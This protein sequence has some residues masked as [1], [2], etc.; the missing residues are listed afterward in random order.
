M[1]QETEA[2]WAGDFGRAYTER[3]A[4]TVDQAFQFF[5]HV[6]CNSRMKTSK[7]DRVLELGANR[8]HNL[9]AIKRQMSWVRT[10]AV[11]INGYAIEA[12]IEHGK[13]GRAHV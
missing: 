1:K 12:M 4:V 8:G 10:T 9:A 11:E 7:I 3:N 2:F 13:I 5:E 6:T